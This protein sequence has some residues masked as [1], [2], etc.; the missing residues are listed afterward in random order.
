[1][2]GP[3]Y[4]KLLTIAK[5]LETRSRHQV[6]QAA[7]L[8]EEKQ[9]AKAAKVAQSARINA[10]TARKTLEKATTRMAAARKAAMTRAEKLKNEANRLLSESFKV[11][12]P[13]KHREM[14]AE[15]VRMKKEAEKR[16]KTAKQLENEI[17]AV[18]PLEDT[19]FDTSIIDTVLHIATVGYKY[20]PLATPR[21]RGIRAWVNSALKRYD[22]ATVAKV[23]QNVMQKYPD[24]FASELY[25]S[26]GQGP[27]AISG[28][29]LE[30][31]SYFEEELELVV[32]SH[33]SIKEK[34][35]KFGSDSLSEIGTPW[36]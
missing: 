6:Y 5:R 11:D 21:A 23:C 1:M 20:A 2:K 13:E 15:A 18:S 14:V 8:K 31:Q 35:E 22:R 12:S 19:S 9:H 25:E 17:L 34:Y 3:G 28:L 10:E 16:Q 4:K 36:E 26:D 33:E 29:Y 32:G 7:K 24:L 30:A 27:E